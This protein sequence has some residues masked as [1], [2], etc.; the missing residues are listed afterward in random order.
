MDEYT[1]SIVCKINFGLINQPQHSLHFERKTKEII[2]SKPCQEPKAVVFPQLKAMHKLSTD[3]IL[4]C[5]IP[6]LSTLK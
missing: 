3:Y 2:S 4:L 6:A 5:L 1:S